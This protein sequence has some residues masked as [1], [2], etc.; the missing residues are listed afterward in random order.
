[1]KG[2]TKAEYWQCILYIAPMNEKK[3]W[4]EKN[5]NGTYCEVCKTQISYHSLKNSKGVQQHME[6]SHKDLLNAYMKK[7]NEVKKCNSTAMDHFFQTAE[8][9]NAKTVSITDQQH[10]TKLIARWT[11]CCLRPFSISEDK[12]Y[13]LHLILHHKLRKI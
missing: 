7:R 10:F 13:K 11:V 8:I 6:K 12:I 5:A 1:M 9:K 3:I 4:K 2:V